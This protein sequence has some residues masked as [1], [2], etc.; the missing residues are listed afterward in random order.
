MTSIGYRRFGLASKRSIIAFGVVGIVLSFSNSAL[1]GDYK[2][3]SPNV[4]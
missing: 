4:V 3:Y 2:V 1:A